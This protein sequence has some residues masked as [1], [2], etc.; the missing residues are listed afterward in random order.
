MDRS[1]RYVI[2]VDFGTLSTRA[3][4]ADLADGT[5]CAA[6]SAA[7]PRGIFSRPEGAADD[8][9]HMELQQPMDYLA[10][11][12]ETVRHVMTGVTPEAVTA[13]GIDFT[14]CTCLPLSE[15]MTPLCCDARFSACPDAYAKLW[16]STAV[17]EAERVLAAANAQCLPWLRRT[18]GRVSAEWLLPKLLETTERAPEVFPA[19]AYYMEAGDWL[20]S[21]LCGEI[22]RGENMAAFKNFYL[23]GYPGDGFFTA[24]SPEWNGLRTGALR[25]RVVPVGEKAGVLCAPAAERLGLRPGIAVTAAMTDAHIG[26]LSAGL[27]LPGEMLSIFGT[28]ACHILHADRETDI[29]GIACWT[30]DGIVPGVYSY[31]ANQ[32]MGDGFERFAER[33]CPADIRAAAE[34]NGESVYAVLNRRAAAMRPG[35]SGLTALDWFGG[36]RCVLGD[37]RL[38]GVITGLTLDTTPM[39]I[40]HALL[41]AA[42]FSVREIRDNFTSHGLPVR[43]MVAMGGLANKNAALMQMVSDVLDLPVEVSEASEGAALGSAIY[44]A[45]LSEYSSIPEAMRAMATPIRKVYR[46]RPRESA[47]YGILYRRFAALH[48]LLGREHPDLIRRG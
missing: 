37:A 4:L 40:Y 28:S 41:E 11:L 23:D 1:E 20:V 47:Q 16:R 24:I 2:G 22:L 29:R 32:L 35:Q 31:E 26:V 36:N 30:R 38:T 17:P 18:G 5:V 27:T 44:A 14:S 3:V 25:G 7:Y 21:R 12:E 9:R 46:P 19:C 45:A 8:G 43:R 6:H 34:R 10:A 33:F 13:L 15:D 48:D 39:D 42:A